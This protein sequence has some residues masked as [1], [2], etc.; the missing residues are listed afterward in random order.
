MSKNLA[1]EFMQIAI[2]WLASF[3]FCVQTLVTD[4]DKSTGR[5]RDEVNLKTAIMSFINAVL[6]KGAGEVRSVLY[7]YDKGESYVRDPY[8]TM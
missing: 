7:V 1:L 3:L 2:A 5:Y 6:S 4:L 8:F